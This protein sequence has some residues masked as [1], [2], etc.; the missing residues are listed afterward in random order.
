PVRAALLLDEAVL[1]ARVEE[2]REVWVLVRL[3]DE[4]LALPGAGPLAPREQ[5]EAA[6]LTGLAAE[7]DGRADEAL[8]RW[9]RAAGLPLSREERRFVDV[10][11]QRHLIALG[12]LREA[13]ALL[14]GY[15]N[16]PGE[17]GR[18]LRYRNGL[19]RFLSG[20][21]GALLAMGRELLGH[22]SVAETAGDP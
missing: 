3:L 17:L 12:Q 15:M 22:R 4:E 19:A 11:R 9:N 21:E 14:D 5:A 13:R 20:D 18:Y 16:V 1:R 10:R 8:R 7:H 2:W 6:I